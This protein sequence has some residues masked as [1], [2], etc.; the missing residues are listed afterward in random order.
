MTAAPT[1]SDCKPAVN[2]AGIGCSAW[3]GVTVKFK[4]I[5]ADPP[6]PIGDFPAWY[7]EDR[8][9]GREREI[10]HNPT[11]YK[12]M[13]LEEIKDLPVGELAD[14]QSHLYLW[15]TDGF[16]EAALDIM[17]AWGFEK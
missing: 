9:S 13:T 1:A 7:D 8:R 11:P 12:T 14:G 3:S 5:V 10:G 16:M 15:T 4:T 2:A 6:W 17:R